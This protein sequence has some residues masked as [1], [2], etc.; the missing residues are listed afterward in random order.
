[1]DYL[2]VARETNVPVLLVEAKA[3]DKPFITP[4]AK[5]ANSSYTHA[6]LMAQAI[7]HW[8][9]G[10]ERLESPSTADWHDYLGQVG[11]Y[12]RDLRDRYSHS[13]PRAVLASGQWF[14]VFKRPIATF[15]D[16]TPRA[17]DI[18]IF[19]LPDLRERALEFYG[20]LCKPALVIETPHHIRATEASNYIT[21]DG[22]VACFHALH[23]SYEGKRSPCPT[24]PRLI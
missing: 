12:V 8:R 7:E 19:Q 23:L 17:V 5:G 2:G 24:F 4:S 15:L 16:E 22:L 10:G 9:G 14:V 3:F 13:L 20:L 1:M 11:K 18:E 21:S 6:D